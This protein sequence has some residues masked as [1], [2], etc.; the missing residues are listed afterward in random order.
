MV[1]AEE[2]EENICVESTSPGERGPNR[3]RSVDIKVS[4]VGTASLAVFKD[5]KA[6][7]KF[8]EK[9]KSKRSSC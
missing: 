4:S 8:L 2:L 6:F 3:V 1:F 5:P 7:K 9:W